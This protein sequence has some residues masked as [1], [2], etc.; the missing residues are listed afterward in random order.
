MSPVIIREVGCLEAEAVN[1]P[2]TF[3]KMNSQAHVR[4]HV[5][6][7]HDIGCREVKPLQ[8]PL[9]YDLMFCLMLYKWDN[10]ASATYCDST[11]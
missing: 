2:V 9:H 7:V 8:M 11:Q 10:A 5:S 1:L 4:L 3:N 6:A